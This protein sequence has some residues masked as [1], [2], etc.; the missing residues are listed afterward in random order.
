VRPRNEEVAIGIGGADE[1]ITAGG[2][3][4]AIAIGVDVDRRTPHIA[5]GDDATGESDRVVAGE[6][7]NG[8]HIVA[9]CRVGV[10]HRDGTWRESVGEG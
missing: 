1:V 7:L 5:V 6:I 9:R 2:I 10:G 4:H 8:L 3:G